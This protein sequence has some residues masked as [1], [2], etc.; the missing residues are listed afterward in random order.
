MNI[1]FLTNN[2][3]TISLYE[4]LKNK[5]DNVYLCED[6]IT[7]DY[8]ISHKIDY[9]VSFNYKYIIGADII[10]YLKEKCI[11]MHISYLPY[12]R[13]S[14]PNFWSFIENTPKGVT[15]HRLSAT[16]DTGDILCQ[17]EISFNE[18]NETLKT[19]YDRLINEIKV[20]FIDN[21]DDL[22]FN[23]CVPIKQN[24]EQATYHNIKMFKECC[25]DEID[26]NMT[27][28]NIKKKLK[29]N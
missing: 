22:K 23:K 5:E 29:I 7:L 11:N 10:D 2:D 27:I 9:L 14:N 16:L 15:I 3:N 25:K 21:W 17:K 8:I 20:L 26:Y 18:E 13:G 1:L 24:E 12:N 28:S 6:K 19:S 4:W